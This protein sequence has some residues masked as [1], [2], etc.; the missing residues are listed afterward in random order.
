MINKKDNKQEKNSIIIFNGG[1]LSID[2]HVQIENEFRKELKYVANN[3]GTAFIQVGNAFFTGALLKQAFSQEEINQKIKIFELYKTPTE[4][5]IIG[6]PST[7]SIIRNFSENDHITD[8]KSPTKRISEYLG[9]IKGTNKGLYLNIPENCQFDQPNILIL[10]EY[11]QDFRKERHLWPSCISSNKEELPPTFLRCSFPLLCEEKP[12]NKLLHHLLGKSNA[13]SNLVLCTTIDDLRRSNIYIK[14]GLSWESTA[15]DLVAAFN[16]DKLAKLRKAAF[17][18]VIISRFGAF[19]YQN[20]AKSDNKYT[21]FYS[22]NAME[23]N[24]D[25]ESKGSLHG[26]NTGLMIHVIFSFANSLI[27]NNKGNFSF[28]AIKEGL[29]HGL[30]GISEAFTNG[31]TKEDKSK[32]NSLETLHFPGEILFSRVREKEGIIDGETENFASSVVPSD[33]T[34]EQK[35]TWNIISQQEQSIETICENIIRTAA[36][37]NLN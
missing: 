10:S 24:N 28:T 5:N 8:R 2:Y 18:I 14:H 13:D 37:L 11:N 23:E 26:L 31:F 20:K 1:D 4:L 22:K 12:K 21:L 9:G 19:L 35:T 32:D 34:Q 36:K 33:L 6:L 27:E 30:E 7:F 29:F 16:S 25:M 17:I 15:L 3:G